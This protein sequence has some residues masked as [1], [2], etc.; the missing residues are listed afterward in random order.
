[1]RLVTLPGDLRA[2]EVAV[3]GFVVGVLVLS[4]LPAVAAAADVPLEAPLNPA[5][6][7][8]QTSGSLSARASVVPVPVEHP[9]GYIPSPL[10]YSHLTGA[11]ATSTIR[12][13]IV[14]ATTLPAAYDLRDYNRVTPVRD[15]GQC[16]ACWAFGSVASL[17]SGLLPTEGDD[18]SENNLKNTSGFDLA[19]CDGGNGDMATA[20]FSRWSGPINEADDPYS[21]T[22]STS[23]SNLAPVKHVMDSLV[24]PPRNSYNL[25]DADAIKQAVMTYGAVTTSIFVDSGASSSRLSAYYKPATASYY[26]NY[27]NSINHMVAIVGWDDNYAA[28]NFATT[29]PGNGAFIVKNSWGTSWGDQG[30]FYVSYYDTS[31]GQDN[32]VF[33]TAQ[34]VTTYNRVYLYDPLGTTSSMG[35][36]STIGWFANIFTAQA[37]EQLKAVAF[38]TLD[39][40]TQYEVYVYTGVTAGAPRS[41]SLVAS[42]SG[43]IA[44]AGS[45]TVVLTTPVQLTQGQRFSVVVK[46]TAST[47]KY[48][49]PME[50]PYAGYSST[51]TANAGESFISFGGT[52]WADITT[53]YANTNVCL[54][55]FAGQDSIPPSIGSFVVPTPATSHTIPITALTATDNVGVTGYLVTASATLPTAADPGWS[56]SAPTGYP[57]TG[58]GTI[59]LYGWARDA[60]GNVSAPATAQVTVAIPTLSVAV[61]GSGSGTATSSPAGISCT[62]GSCSD[63]YDAGTPVTIY[64]TPSSTSLFTGW[65]GDCSGTG[66]CSL[67]MS[68]D[69]TV[70]ATFDQFPPVKAGTATMGYYAD[71]ATAYA[72]APDASLFTIQAQAVEFIGDLLLN[73]NVAVD[74]SGGYDSIFSTVSG[75]STISGTLTIGDGSLTVNGLDIH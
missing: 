41:G 22:S 71:L 11:T 61:A 48:P 45:H 24:I 42:L 16:G 19:A 65:S 27:D 53:S 1:M 46:V 36:N 67:T 69:K 20:Y 66:D 25:P 59:T 70:T 40:S 33:T 26:Y 75:A 35:Y 38:Q 72:A 57:V 73:R 17:E 43:T 32:Y 64:A 10:D 60:V 31:I 9:T 58:N 23:P 29:P 14:T 39:V 28:S 47:Y 37:S 7:S 62:G 21:A 74:F 50:R 49:I 15:Q 30:Y 55:A 12:S 13:A 34:P 52:S 54:K 2:G 6:L 44:N 51:A 5:F 56:A 18:F 4:L 8:Y 3:K 63:L 68:G